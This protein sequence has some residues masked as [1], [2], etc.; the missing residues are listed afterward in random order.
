MVGFNAQIA[1]DVQGAG[2]IIS[3]TV[4]AQGCD[5]ELLH[6]VLEPIEGQLGAGR[7]KSSSI[8]ATRV[9]AELMRSKRTSGSK[10][11]TLLDRPGCRKSPIEKMRTPDQRLV[12]HMR[13]LIKRRV[14]LAHGQWLRRRRGQWPKVPLGLSK[15]RWVSSNS[16]MWVGKKMQTEWQLVCLA[17][18]SAN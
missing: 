7:K 16:M 10:L 1:V 14:E 2:L 9:R 3:N 13:H 15:E 17:L 8:P 5:A 18:T 12:R 11:F 4:G 6:Q